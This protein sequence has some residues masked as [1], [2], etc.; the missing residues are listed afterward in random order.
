MADYRYTPD[1]TARIPQLIEALRSA[2]P[3]A[4]LDFEFKDTEGPRFVPIKSHALDPTI[5]GAETREENSSST[6]P[7]TRPE[8]E[9]YQ[10]LINTNRAKTYAVRPIRYDEENVPDS[11]VGEIELAMKKLDP[12]LLKKLQAMLEQR[13]MWTRAALL[14]QFSKDEI[15]LLDSKKAY[16]PACCYTFQDCYLREILIR[17]NYDPRKDPNS[18][19]HIFDGKTFHKSEA[20]Y[21]LIDITDRQLYDLIRDPVARR[22]SPDAMSG[23]YKQEALNVIKAIIR[24]KWVALSENRI[25]TDNDCMDLVEE[26]YSRKQLTRA[27]EEVSHGGRPKGGGGYVAGDI[28]TNTTAQSTSKKDKWKRKAIARLP[29]AAEDL[30][31]ARL[32][33]TLEREQRLAMQARHRNDDGSFS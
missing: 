19:I 10:R 7:N 1:T 5:T 22:T 9:E 30:T 28:P 11:P 26:F 24:R 12:V 3:E 15:K 33:E 25:C 17:F 31:A 4:L 2:N 16:I 29:A 6:L 23:W 20:T 13:P 27:T 8:T 18:Y 21:Q 14:N 32:H